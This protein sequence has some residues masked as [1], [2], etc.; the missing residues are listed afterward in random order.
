M[1]H[2]TF[3][4]LS[5]C[6]NCGIKTDCSI[7]GTRVQSIVTF[8]ALL[9]LVII[10]RDE[11]FIIRSFI[12]IVFCASI[13]L[14]GFLIHGLVR[15]TSPPVASSSSSSESRETFSSSSSS[16]SDGPLLD[17]SSELSSSISASNSWAVTA[18]MR[19]MASS[20]PI[21][22]KVAAVSAPA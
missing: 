19:E 22:T 3:L 18:L 4:F 13:W 8:L 15:A 12:K 16:Q 7:P 10:T 11:V 6:K 1:V 2:Q 20:M 14:R 9:L 17:S 21:E 5:S